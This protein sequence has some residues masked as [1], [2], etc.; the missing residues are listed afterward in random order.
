MNIKVHSSEL[1]RMMKTISQ[2]INQQFAAYS[3][4]EISHNDNLLTIRGTNGTY[5]ASV[6]TP[7][8]GGDN[9]SFCVDGTMFA[10]VCSMCSGEV[11]ISTDGKVCTI[12]GAGRTRIPIVNADI[13]KYEHVSGKVSVISGDNLARCF[14]GVSY[15]ISNDQ[16]RLQLTGV[17]CQFGE[18]GV[19]MVALDGFQM[20]VET[21]QCNGEIMN[22]IVPGQFL[23]LVVQG[24]IPD[25]DITICT[26]GTRIEAI[27]DSMSITCG[28]LSGEYPD[29]NR[30]LPKEFKTECIVKTEEFKNALKCGSIIA[31]KQNL[32][33]LEIGNESIR[34]MSNSDE[35]DYDADVAG[36]T[37]GDGLT[38]AFNQKYLMN[39]INAI[40]AEEVVLRFNTS[41]TPCVLQGKDIVGIRL[42]LP[43]RVA[44]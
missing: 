14:N 44:G 2:C 8:L 12:K 39:S 18:Y 37:H 6:S 38:I 1:N 42:L 3:N 40:T 13:P 24:A 16:S 34:I 5:Q 27:S 36:S 15:A 35:A 32:V 31:N 17:Y 43:V 20:S 9:E 25:E 26:N 28:L 7:L 4:I 33:K 29:Y 41:V 23:K 21:A 30:I 11:S 22:A 19:K 10:K